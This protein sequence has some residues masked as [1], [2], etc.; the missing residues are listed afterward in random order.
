MYEK[1][2]TI[3]SRVSMMTRF[4]LMGLTAASLPEVHLRI[5]GMIKVIY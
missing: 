3:F 1:S 4:A 2:F 5:Q